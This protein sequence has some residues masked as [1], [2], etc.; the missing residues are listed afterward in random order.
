M[1]SPLSTGIIKS[2]KTLENS[3]LQKILFENPKEKIDL[4]KHLNSSVPYI[5]TKTNSSSISFS[6]SN[7][8]SSINYS[9]NN[10]YI[11]TDNKT[12]NEQKNGNLFLGKKTKIFFNVN[13]NCQKKQLFMTN[14]IKEKLIINITNIPQD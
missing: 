11:K 7:D 4:F 8:N 12:V 13:K 9:F 5:Q 6:S 14:K 3:S 1:I 10:Q 2:N